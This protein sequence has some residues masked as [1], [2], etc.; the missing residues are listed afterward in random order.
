MSGSTAHAKDFPGARKIVEYFSD[1]KFRPEKVAL[2]FGP[3]GQAKH[4]TAVFTND[5]WDRHSV[6]MW[7]KAIAAHEKHRQATRAMRSTEG[8]VITKPT[9]V[10]KFNK[11]ITKKTK[12]VTSKKK[13]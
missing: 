11:R 7:R 8:T 13:R 4:M 10:K 3:H 2:V 9:P 6:K 12:K 1:G 5:T